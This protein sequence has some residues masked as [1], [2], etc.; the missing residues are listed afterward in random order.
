MDLQT[1]VALSI[2]PAPSRLRVAEA[3]REASRSTDRRS[4]TLERLLAAIGVSDRSRTAIRELRVRA[5]ELIERTVAL[6]AQTVCWGS[7]QYPTALAAIPDPPAV[8]WIRGSAE[9]LAMPCV[10]IVGSRAASPYALEV[11]D[12]LAAGLAS[13]G[14]VVVSGLARGVDSAAHRG[15]LNAA[16]R[17]VGVLGSGVDEVYPREHE[18]LAA[19]LAETGAVISELPPG[20]PPLAWHFPLRNRIISGLALAIVVVEASDKSGSLTT[21]RAALDQGREVLVV[22][23]NVLSGRNGGSHRLIKD[24]AKIVERA[25]DILQE[26]GWTPATAGGETQKTFGTSYLAQSSEPILNAMCEGESYDLDALIEL[27][28]LDGS[29]ILPRL[30]ELELSGRVTRIDGGRFV[31]PGGKW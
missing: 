9:V 4:A 3:L 11:A 16:G 22:P 10:A 19:A 20:A 5:A 24:G 8:L 26:I 14:L 12:R 13:H 29:K 1:A 23:G 7:P 31:R 6:G 21:A 18:R 25:D 27:S 15:T 30:L 28:G 17:S 2:A